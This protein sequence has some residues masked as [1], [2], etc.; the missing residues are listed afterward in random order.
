[1]H[2]SI[3]G[4]AVI[5]KYCSQMLTHSLVIP[6]MLLVIVFQNRDEMRLVKRSIFIKL[7]QA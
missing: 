7:I 3:S 4:D 5:F 1:M 6:P 2:E